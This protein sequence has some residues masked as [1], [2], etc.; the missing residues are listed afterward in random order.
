MKTLY[1][2]PAPNLTDASLAVLGQIP[3]ISIL[4][5][6]GS[7]VTDAGL[8]HL[9]G[10][11]LEILEVSG[12]GV[13]DAGLAALAGSS[14]FRTLGLP[15][16]SIT[17]AG[18]AALSGQAKLQWLALDRTKVDDSAVATLASL[19]ALQTLT[20]AGTPLTDAGLIALVQGVGPLKELDVSGTKVT[21]RGIAAAK[22]L[23]PG[24]SIQSGP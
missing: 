3:A 23:K 24:L 6:T 16:T 14:Q 11:R 8:E 15:G 20:L 13:T 22:A 1:L 9:R 18:L 12:Q 2:T 4:L 5:L 19:P 21:A 10:L 7:N 17:G